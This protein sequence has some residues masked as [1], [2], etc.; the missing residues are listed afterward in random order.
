MIKNKTSICCNELISRAM[1]AGM[2]EIIGRS[3]VTAALVVSGLSQR[4]PGEGSLNLK[5]G[6]TYAELRALQ[7]GLEE[8]YGDCA[9]WGVLLRCGRASF[10]HIL[11]TAGDQSGLSS[12]EFRLLPTTHRLTAGLREVATI[13]AGES[14]H[15]VEVSEEADAWIWRYEDCPWCKE[16]QQQRCICH[17]VIGLLEE[18][19]NWASGGKTYPLTET[20]CMAAGGDACVIRIEKR[21]LG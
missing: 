3:G 5:D 19:F 2:Q 11:R 17:F 7:A 13:L 4:L 1:F 16:R 12:R 15:A 20:E 18:Y 10:K 21:T 6:M 9:G 14:R 8:M